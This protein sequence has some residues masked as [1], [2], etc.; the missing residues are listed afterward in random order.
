MELNMNFLAVGA[1]VLLSFILGFRVVR[2]LIYETLD[3]GNGLR[4]TYALFLVAVQSFFII[5]GKFFGLNN[6]F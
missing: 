1:C 4:P 5:V 2:R 6:L 3:K